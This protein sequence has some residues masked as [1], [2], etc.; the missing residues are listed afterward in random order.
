MNSV[1]INEDLL[2]FCYFSANFYNYI[3]GSAKDF[4]NMKKEESEKKNLEKGQNPT[5]D[6]FDFLNQENYLNYIDNLSILHCDDTNSKKHK[7]KVANSFIGNNFFQNDKEKETENKNIL[8]LCKLKEKFNMSILPNRFEFVK[9]ISI[10]TIPFLFDIYELIYNLFKNMEESNHE[11]IQKIVAENVLSENDLN[12][13]KKKLAEEIIDLKNKIEIQK[14]LLN[15]N[16]TE[17]GKLIQKNNNLEKEIIRLKTDMKNLQNQIIL[18]KNESSDKIKSLI[19]ELKDAKKNESHSEKEPANSKEKISLLETN[20]SQLKEKITNLETELKELK[21]KIIFLEEELRML[22]EKLSNLENEFA[23][24]KKKISLLQ[25][26]LEENKKE[27]KEKFSLLQKELEEN[28]KELEENKK[29]LEEKF[30]LLKKEMKEEIE[31]LKISNSYLNEKLEKAEGG[32][33]QMNTQ[34]IFD[35]FKTKEE[36]LGK[37]PEAYID[38]NSLVRILNLM[39]IDYEAVNNKLRE[40]EKEIADL[41]KEQKQK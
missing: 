37:K 21:E 24:S 28:K 16:E 1:A 6:N 30:S 39:S 32:Y 15:K 26:E 10:Q 27:S 41:K 5:K 17:K 12:L 25:K 38:G 22:K 3:S 9:L 34:I 40:K 8:L 4:K 19:R 36:N 2:N 35:R 11:K 20:L 29:E 14:Q 13:S 18:S 33:N 23:E 31:K 7:I